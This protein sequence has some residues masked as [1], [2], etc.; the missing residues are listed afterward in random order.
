MIF[1]S[2]ILSEGA[3]AHGNM[4]LFQR[5]KVFREPTGMGWSS[6]RPLLRDDLQENRT[7][8]L[9]S[10]GLRQKNVKAME[11]IAIRRATRFAHRWNRSG[12]SAR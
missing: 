7:P 11:L 3:E 6:F 9:V 1:D 5:G 10:G 4:F 8:F 12:C 2:S